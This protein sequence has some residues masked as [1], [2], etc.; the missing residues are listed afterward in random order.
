M[1]I[2]TL[3]TWGGR[4][5]QPLL[6]FLETYKNV[7]ILCF[8]EIYHKS[9]KVL[10]EDKGDK[11][12]LFSDLVSILK[13]HEGYFNPSIPSYGLALFISKNLHIL[14]QGSKM[15]YD[16]P[17]YVSGANHPRNLQYIRFIDN[18]KEFTIINVHGLWT[19]KGKT[20]TEDRLKQSVAIKNYIDSLKGIKILCGDFNLLPDTKSVSILEKG[21][22][23]LIKEYNITS[24]RTEFYG[25]PER[26]ADYIFISPELKVKDFRVLPDKVSDHSPLFLEI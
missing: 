10:V 2:I 24:T 4:V 14:E 26:Y 25:K 1:K 19:G 18:G 5:Y 12:N 9:N 17:E 11:L 22:R 23:N 13:E 16:N 7:D 21:M 8:Q 6:D 15:I 20:D 3:N